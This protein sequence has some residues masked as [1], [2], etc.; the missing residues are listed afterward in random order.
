MATKLY[1]VAY[2]NFET[3]TGTRSSVLIDFPA[4][5]PMAAEAAKHVAIYN[6]VNAKYG[7]AKVIP[8][9]FESLVEF[10]KECAAPKAEEPVPEPGKLFNMIIGMP[11]DEVA[12]YERSGDYGVAI[13]DRAAKAGKFVKEFGGFTYGSPA[14]YEA[15]IWVKKLNELCEV[16]GETARVVLVPLRF[17]SVTTILKKLAEAASAAR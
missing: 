2:Y 8:S 10:V 7:I 9:D 1:A 11:T 16:T 14:C 12:T 4:G 6:V 15:A 5:S 17:D 3:Q 13:I